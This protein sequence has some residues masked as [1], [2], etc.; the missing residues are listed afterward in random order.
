MSDQLHA[1]EH[2]PPLFELIDD[3]DEDAAY[4]AESRWPVPFSDDD[5]E[6][7]DAWWI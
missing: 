3:L 2:R 7:R 1:E 5:I 6:L 4:D